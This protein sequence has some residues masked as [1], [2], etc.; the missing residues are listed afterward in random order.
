MNL[1]VSKPAT[2]TVQVFMLSTTQKEHTPVKCRQ[3][4]TAQPGTWLTPS[5]CCAAQSGCK[6]CNEVVKHQHNT[7]D[8]IVHSLL[9]EHCVQQYLCD[10]CCLQAGALHHVRNVLT[11]SHAALGGAVLLKLTSQTE[12]GP[13]GNSQA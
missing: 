5:Q 2:A 7:I 11:V 3:H 6:L 9:V 10:L 8:G 1:P 4:H 12:S 13:G